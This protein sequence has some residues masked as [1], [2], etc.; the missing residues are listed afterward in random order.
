MI[1]NGGSFATDT[2]AYLVS[3]L[4]TGTSNGIGSLIFNGG[5]FNAGA[6]IWGGSG[7][8]PAVVINNGS[9]FSPALPTTNLVSAGNGAVTSSKYAT[10]TNCNSAASPAV[11]GSAA[12][13]SVSIAASSSSVIVNTSAVTANSQITVTFDGSLGTKLGITC[14]TTAQQP[15]VSARMAGT[16]FHD[17]RCKQILDASRLY[18]VLD[19]KLG[20]QRTVVGTPAPT[21]ILEGVR[22]TK[23]QIQ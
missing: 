8:S 22:E 14:N 16:S 11:C 21:I 2:N 9:T 4:P 15:Y 12:A 5:L 3:T 18:L 20:R 19:N 17:I 10:A 7:P 6:G 23:K 13:G 1:F